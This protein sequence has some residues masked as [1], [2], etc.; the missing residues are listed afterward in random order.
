MTL[1]LIWFC[2]AVVEVIGHVI[3]RLR[4]WTTERRTCHDILVDSGSDY[5]LKVSVRCERCRPTE[6]SHSPHQEKQLTLG[7]DVR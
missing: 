1:M 3:E 7:M 5:N 2:R 6:L 4:W